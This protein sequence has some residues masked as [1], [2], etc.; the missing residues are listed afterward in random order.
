VKNARLY[1][2]AFFVYTLLGVLTGF[3]ILKKYREHSRPITCLAVAYIRTKA[4][5]R[6]RVPFKHIADTQTCLRVSA[7]HNDL[8][9]AGFDTYQ[10][11]SE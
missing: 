2:R 4:R 3:S 6:V 7:K 1:W 10:R 11:H 8:E 5:P 9:E